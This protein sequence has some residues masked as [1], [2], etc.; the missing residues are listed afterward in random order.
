MLD[1]KYFMLMLFFSAHAKQQERYKLQERQKLQRDFMLLLCC[2]A[3]WLSPDTTIKNDDR[4]LNTY[5]SHIEHMVEFDCSNS[6]V[7]GIHAHIHKQ[8][9]LYTMLGRLSP[10]N[11]SF[12]LLNI[13]MRYKY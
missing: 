11:L 6:T 10:D 8:R 12:I 9:E 13:A 2:S 5:S 4:M 7:C 3:A 1:P